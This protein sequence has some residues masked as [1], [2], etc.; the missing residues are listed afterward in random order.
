MSNENN[1]E[2]GGAGELLANGGVR[3][4]YIRSELG[5]ASSARKPGLG[6]GCQVWN[7]RP[8]GT[9]FGSRGMERQSICQLG[10]LLCNLLPGHIPP[11]STEARRKSFE[12]RYGSITTGA[13]YR[14]LCKDFTA[15]KFDPESWADLVKRSGAKYAGIC[16]IHH[17]GYA[18]WDS[19]ITPHSAG[20]TGPKRDLLGEILKAFEERDLKTIATFHHART[21]QQFQGKRKG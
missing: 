1:T 13:G 14:D 3:H 6:P 19:A 16:A 8:L 20:T 10:E 12:K 2:D 18:M 21:Y 5:F 7:L 17:D 4:D 11:R 9:L 15:S